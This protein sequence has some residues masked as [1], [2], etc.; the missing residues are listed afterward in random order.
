MMPAPKG[1]IPWNKG[2][3]KGFVNARGDHFLYIVENGKRRAKKE[4]RII[5]EK[6]LG[7]DLEPWEIVHHINED[8]SDNRIENLGLMDWGEHTSLHCKGKIVT[9]KHTKRSLEIHAQM[10]EE[11]KRLRDYNERI[12]TQKIA[13]VE[14]LKV[15]LGSKD[16][17][18][19]WL[20]DNHSAK[21]IAGLP[22]AAL[23][24][25]IAHFALALVEGD[26]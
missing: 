13:L 2:T 23:H 10:R 17:M 12:E 6:H 18:V 25:Y 11:I 21:G 19:Q 14:A 4:S 1:Q 7:R 20:I 16:E 22:V 15:I 3:S 8:P 5:M 24:T 9:S 26:E